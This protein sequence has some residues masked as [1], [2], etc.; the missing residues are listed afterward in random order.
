MPQMNIFIQDNLVNPFYIF[1]GHI[2]KVGHIEDIF[3]QGSPRSSMTW[4]SN[5][6]ISQGVSA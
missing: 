1:S 5:F 6:C 3:F 2:L 4:I